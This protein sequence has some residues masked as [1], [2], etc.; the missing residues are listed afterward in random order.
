MPQQERL[1]L[2]LR[3]RLVLLVLMIGCAYTHGYI[4]SRLIEEPA[5]TNSLVE[6]FVYHLMVLWWG[7]LLMGVMALLAGNIASFAI[8]FIFDRQVFTMRG[9]HS[10]DASDEGYRHSTDTRGSS[11]DSASAETP[12]SASKQLLC[13]YLMF[14]STSIFLLIRIIAWVLA[15]SRTDW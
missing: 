11:I 7:G 12:I 3:Q 15:R 6:C 4:L 9:E 14:F 8:K 10:P 1:K 2:R 13:Y 5:P